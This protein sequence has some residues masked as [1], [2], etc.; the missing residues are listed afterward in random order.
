MH[1]LD[2]ALVGAAGSLVW[3]GEEGNSR[4][5]EGGTGPVFKANV[6]VCVCVCVC[7][8]YQK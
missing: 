6:C 7:I 5:L 1:P 3:P 8:D 4:Y 2:G